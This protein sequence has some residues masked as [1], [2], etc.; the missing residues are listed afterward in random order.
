[1]LAGGVAE[2]LAR[3]A[4]QLREDTEVLDA[5][6]ADLLADARY[7][8]GRGSRLRCHR[9]PRPP[10]VRRRV[11]REWLRAEGVTALT[12]AHLRAADLLAAP[13][14]DR[15]GVALPGGLELMR[16]H[17]RLTLRPARW[18]TA[19]PLPREDGHRVRR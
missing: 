14:P 11:L 19:S 6:A 12:D 4:A 1:M 10:A 18:S 5:L 15:S 2:A 13:G 7:R 16:G 17:G 8:D 3:T 9:W